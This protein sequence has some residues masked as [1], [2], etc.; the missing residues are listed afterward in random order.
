MRILIGMEHEL[1][2][3]GLI[4]LLKDVRSLEY[5]VTARSQEELKTAAGKYPFDM[6]LLDASLKGIGSY[7]TLFSFPE[8]SDRRSCKRVVMYTEPLSTLESL[9]E[10]KE[11]DGLFHEETSLDEM[12]MFFDRI[13]LGERL[14]LKVQHGE[15]DNEGPAEK[16]SLSERELEIFQ[17][18]VQGYSVYDTAS[19][20]NIS[21][22]TVDNHRRNIKK[23]LKIVKNEEWIDRAK[24]FGLL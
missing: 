22:K 18:K 14:Y 11:I 15:K 17:L 3:Y 6:V 24:A 21:N 13:I 5:M 19:I 4:Q 9:F 16:I 10:K 23:K 12:M 1:L 2:R 20:L 7:R 8:F